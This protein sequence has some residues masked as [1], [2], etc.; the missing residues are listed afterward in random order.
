MPRRGLDLDVQ[1]KTVGDAVARQVLQRGQGLARVAAGMPA[2]RI[3]LGELGPGQVTAGAVAVGRALQRGVVHQKGHA[4]AAQLGVAL[5]HA[6][7]VLGAQPE[8]GQGVFRGQLARATVG[9]PAGVG[10]GGE[11]GRGCAHAGSPNFS[12]LPWGSMTNISFMPQGWTVGGASCRPRAVKSACSKP[13]SA[14]T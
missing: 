5:E 14:R 3:Q 4:V 8:R 13:V 1:E 9:D 6:V 2:T 7:A 12:R 10:P 11:G